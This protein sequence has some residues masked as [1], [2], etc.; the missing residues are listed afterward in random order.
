MKPFWKTSEFWGH[1]LTTVGTVGAAV[2]GV[3]PATVA[4]VVVGVS[5]GA[6][7]L[8]RAITKNAVN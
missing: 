5:Q 1:L 6:Y 4:A 3:V 7:A 8:A 2:A